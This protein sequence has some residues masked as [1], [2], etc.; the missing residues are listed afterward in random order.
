M[1]ELDVLGK[2]IQKFGKENLSDILHFTATGL[3]DLFDCKM[4]RIYLEDLYEGMLICQYV[5]GDNPVEQSQITQ[6]ISKESHIS[7]SFYKNQVVASWDFHQ[8]AGSQI[9]ENNP[10]K[11]KS[12]NIFV[13]FPIVYQLR[14]IGSIC[15]DWEKDGDVL[16]EDQVN[17]ISAFLSENGSVI[18][19]AKRFHQKISFSKHLDMARKE[20]AVW[21]MVRSAVKLIDNLTLAAVLIPATTQLGRFK[22]T[23]PSELV[24]I[25]ATFSK[26]SEDV[27][28]HGSKD[29]VDIIKDQNLLNRIVKYNEEKGLVACDS[30]MEPLYI[31]NISNDRVN[32]KSGTGKSN[33]VSLFQV[34]KFSSDNRLI[35]AVN[36]YTSIPHEFTDSEKRLLLEYASM[37][38]KLILEDSLAH[39][40]IQVLSEI[41]ELLS[42]QDNSLQSFLHKI[43][44]K[45]SEL[46]G[47]DC[48]TVSIL[49]I[50]D[51]KPWLVVE[52]DS[53]K[54]IGAKSRGWKKSKISPLPVGGAELPDELKSMNGYSA[55]TARP[56]LANDVNNPE[57]TQGFYKSLSPRI[58]AELA[59]PIIS[60]NSVLGVINQ[61]SFQKNYFT[62]EHKNIVQIVS[63]LISQKVY[64]LKQLEELRQEM[65]HLRRDI[66]YRHPKVSSYHFGNVIGKSRKMHKL[67]TQINTVVRSICNRMLHWSGSNQQEAVMGLPSLLITGGTGSGKEF[68]FNNIFSL[69]T[70]I[71]QKARGLDHKLPL[72]KTNIAAYSGELTY[73]ELFG[74][75]KGAF[76]GAESNRQ[77]ILEE[78]NGGVVFL[79]EI[80]DADPKTQ[81]QLL[82]FLDTGVFTRLGENQPQYSRIFL[83]AATNK[84]LLEEIQKGRFREDLYHRL[85]ALSFHIPSLNER[86]EDIEDLVIHFLGR[87]FNTY[88]TDISDKSQ[89]YLEK[90]AIE[91]LNNFNYRGNVR[92]LKNILLRAT[93]FSEAPVITLENIIAACQVDPLLGDTQTA[94]Y[95][96]SVATVI[97]GN[98]E[99][100]KGNFWSTIHQPFR[101]KELTRDTLKQIIFTAKSRY[102]TN[103]PG[104]AVKLRACA[105]QFH[106]DSSEWK[107][108]LSFKNFLYKTV[109]ISAD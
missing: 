22:S 33:L 65:V 55:Y 52:D 86:R 94:P 1:V 25:I 19:R 42:D 43:L 39:V 102:Q 93:L 61:D 82:R 26:N 90:D 78:A 18:D 68:F 32:R 45:T 64:N 44:D 24:E 106:N 31:K 81:V 71:F 74:H 103:L 101:N 62:E 30:Q 4:V 48:G 66:E 15:L 76:T 83:I 60:G 47:A 27:G 54:L 105:P 70:E 7:Q 5:T 69:I 28:S 14:P 11:Y 59:V 107:K 34:P 77:G 17:A 91:Y 89:P 37:V 3:K 16:T 109:R 98:L 84:N 12:D 100:G 41:E 20:E 23:K 21:R 38:E 63:R 13:A 96:D 8:T 99:S 50:I 29:Q 56:I 108:F 87:L 10:F 53:G 67:V 35:C 51:N 80:G 2:S 49:T 40:E 9:E 72:K 92:E 97:L 73:S 58:Q 95:Q 88:K 36:Y 104:L 85:S 79:D 57:L 6:Y 46:I 75:K